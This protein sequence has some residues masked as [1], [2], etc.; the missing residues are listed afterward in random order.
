MSFI[1]QRSLCHITKDFHLISN[2]TLENLLE[3][4]EGLED[5]CENLSPDFD[6]SLSDGVLTVTFGTTVGTYVI[7]KQTPNRQIW[8]SSPLSGPKRYDWVSEH[9][10]LYK[11]D[12]STLYELLTK[13]ISMI[14]GVHVEFNTSFDSD[15]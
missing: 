5:Y 1:N 13:E 6:V 15:A 14:V 8:L 3:K 2:E 9:G 10:W 4:F 7:N 12:N 11:H